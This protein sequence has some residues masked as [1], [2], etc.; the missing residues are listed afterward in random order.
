MMPAGT[1]GKAPPWRPTA[2]LPTEWSGSGQIEQ[3]P[4]GGSR[5]NVK[6]LTIKMQENACVS[7]TT[8]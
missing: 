5:S 7:H 4:P 6:T 2:N 3:K 1:S 8:L